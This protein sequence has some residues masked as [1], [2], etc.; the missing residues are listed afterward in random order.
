VVVHRDRDSLHSLE[1]LLLDRAD[2]RV[3]LSE[4]IDDAVE[5]MELPGCVSPS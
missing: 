4:S 5:Q 2:Y 1:K 3:S